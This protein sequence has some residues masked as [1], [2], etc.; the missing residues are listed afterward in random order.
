MSNLTSYHV[1][2]SQG[3][4]YGPANASTLRQWV[5]KGRIVAGMSIA[6]EGSANWYEVA[7]H[8]ALADLFGQTAAAPVAASAASPGYAA[9]PSA[10]GPADSLGYRS[11][12]GQQLNILALISMIA[13]ILSLPLFPCCCGVFSIPFAVS[14]IIMGFIA[15]S[16]IKKDPDRYTGKGMA[17]AGII[18]G[19][20]AIALTLAYTLFTFGF[21]FLNAARHGR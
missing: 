3:N 19:F 11:S 18:C 4:T 15:L 8:P 17:I 21:A 16:Q 5:A 13:G 2:D 10:S 7:T 6:E 9:Q 14:A 12:A 1:R 20:C